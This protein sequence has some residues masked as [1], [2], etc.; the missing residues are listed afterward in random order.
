MAQQTKFD[1]FGAGNALLDISCEVTPEFLEQYELKGGNAIL[2]E[3]KH[4]P[5]YKALSEMEKVKYIPGGA[6]MNSVR[7]CSWILG[8]KNRVSYTSC[9]GKDDDYANTLSN[10]LEQEGLT[11]SFQKSE[12]T[13]GTCAV[14]VVNKERSLVANLSA[15]NEYK[16][17]HLMSDE[18]KALWQNAKVV[19]ITGFW[20]T[21][22]P[23]GMVE[24][25]K[26]CQANN[27]P[28]CLN[29]SAPF[30]CQFFKDQLLSVLPYVTVL[31]GNDDEFKA[32][33]QNLNYG[34]E[35]VEEIGKLA[36]KEKS[37]GRTCVC[38]QGKEPTLVF[39]T[40]GAEQYPVKALNQDLIV[41]LNCAG[42]AF[43]GGFLS[44]LIS[45]KSMKRCCDVGNAASRAI[46]QV[47]GCDLSNNNFEDPDQ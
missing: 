18:C 4:L 13:T 38:T 6:C 28:F 41:D 37:S 10:Q 39:T 17:E 14:C 2:A 25:G 12:K 42:D 46:I 26:H 22:C 19:Y 23:E 24:I 3:E 33:A 21:V 32:L 20:L 45:G 43:V 47:S 34:T 44:Q 31:F 16:K 29:I 8:G 15:A 30:L 11:A 1:V 36:V 35:K 27:I 9:I 40:D 7:V 5:I